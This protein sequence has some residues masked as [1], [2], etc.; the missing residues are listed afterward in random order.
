MKADLILK[1]SSVSFLN[2]LISWPFNRIFV[3]RLFYI[4]G[5]SGFFYSHTHN[6][7]Y[8][9]A[10]KKA[11][12]LLVLCCSTISGLQFSL[13][14][15]VD[16]FVYPIYSHLA[17]LKKVETTGQGSQIRFLRRSDDHTENQAERGIQFIQTSLLLEVT[18]K[19]NLAKS[20]LS[21]SLKLLFILLL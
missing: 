8:D 10:K 4:L 19:N 20:K 2:S 6:F 7:G 16:M 15:G 9:C 14:F 1:T 11:L 21:G 5:S 17:I 3:N 13:N 12:E 18:L